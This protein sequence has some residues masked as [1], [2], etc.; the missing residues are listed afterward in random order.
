LFLAR[1]N[2][3]ARRRWFAL[4]ALCA[5]ALHAAVPMGFMI[6]V[7]GGHAQL[8]LCPAIAPTH[9]MSTLPM[10]GMHHHVGGHAASAGSSCAFALAGAAAMVSPAPVLSQPFYVYLQ[11]VRSAAIVSLPAEPPLRHLAPR[12]PPAPV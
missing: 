3:P 7:T 9:P 10:A 12:G 2:K 5:F 8:E 11:P 4:L 1:L 6:G